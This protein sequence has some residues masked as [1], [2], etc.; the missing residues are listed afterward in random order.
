MC[1]RHGVIKNE[2]YLIN[3]RQ[4]FDLWTIDLVIFN[5]KISKKSDWFSF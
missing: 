4:L 1:F 2:K 5:V 3:Y